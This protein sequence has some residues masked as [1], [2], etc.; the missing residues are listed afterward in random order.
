MSGANGG[1]GADGEVLEGF[2]CP[3][4]FIDLNSL[5]QLQAHFEREHGSEDKAVV[6]AFKG[7]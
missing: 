2:L 3:F 7:K 1:A 4:C 6:Q 5:T